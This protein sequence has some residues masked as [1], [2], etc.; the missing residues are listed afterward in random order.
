MGADNAF[1]MFPYHLELEVDI[2][3]PCTKVQIVCLA[4][5]VNLVLLAGCVCTHTKWDAHCN[6][7]YLELPWVRHPKR[8]PGLEVWHGQG[9]PSLLQQSYDQG[10]RSVTNVMVHGC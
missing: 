1:Y 3:Q 7:S 10:Q 4:N 2:L 9:V 8:H 5:I 6:R